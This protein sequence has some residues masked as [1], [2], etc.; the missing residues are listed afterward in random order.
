MPATTCGASKPIAACPSFSAAPG[1]S[2][3][4]LSWTVNSPTIADAEA[5][6]ALGNA[7]GY[8]SFNIKIGYPQTPQYDLQLVGT[9]CNF[10][11]GGFHWADA[12]TSYDVDTALAM[13]P[14]LADAGLKGL[15]SPLPP[16]LIRGYQTLKRQG[17]LPI[18]MDEGIVS[19]VEVAE[20]IALDMFDGIAMKVA[21]CGGLWNASRIVALLRE[22]NLLVFG[23][24]LTDPDLSL[25][26]TA[27]LFAWAKLDAPD[28]AQ[29]AAVHRGARHDRSGIP[30][31]W[32]HDPRPDR[33]RARHYD[34]CPRRKV[35][36]HCGG[37]LD[38]DRVARNSDRY[39]YARPHQAGPWLRKTPQR[40]RPGGSGSS[41]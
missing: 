41:C 34:R 27:H 32:R 6:L 40:T 17:A 2:R 29:W 1:N 22:N 9:V 10:A 36:E 5:Q 16:N 23:S 38:D 8:D 31:Q 20:F 7:R 35:A 12:N 3:C 30:R 14:K 37:S 28:R 25:A 19:P 26:A 24:G 13:A 15:E 39:D 4:E 21:R 11:P 18:L 33:A